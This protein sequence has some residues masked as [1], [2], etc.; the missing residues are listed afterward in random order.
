MLNRVETVWRQLK[1]VDLEALIKSHF[2]QPTVIYQI[3]PF[4]FV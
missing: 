4:V 2:R 3:L 1:S